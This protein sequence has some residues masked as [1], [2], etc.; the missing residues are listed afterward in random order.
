MPTPPRAPDGTP[1]EVRPILRDEL[2][3]ILLRCWPEDPAEIEELFD[4][5]ETIGMAAWEAGR[6][7]GMLHC[8]RVEAPGGTN[9]YWPEWNGWWNAGERTFGAWGPLK[10]DLGVE[11]PAW[12]HACMHVGRTLETGESDQPDSRYFG[13]GIGTALARESVRWAAERDYA[14]V[15][16]PGAPHDLPY[17]AQ[18]MGCLPWT[19]YERLGF[20]PFTA[21]LRNEE[22]APGWAR[23]EVHDPIASEVREALE[24]RRDLHDIL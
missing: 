23:G 22:D 11:G 20:E 7:V 12:C 5:Q 21:H 9:E 2:D 17:L 18:W 24:G 14:A 8:Y 1:I 3:R 13:R 19:T 10:A 4:L 15:V 6:S 16:A